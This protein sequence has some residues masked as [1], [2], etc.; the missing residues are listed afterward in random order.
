MKLLFMDTETT[1]VD[2]SIHGLTQIAGIVDEV[3][4]KN[5]I[6]VPNEIGRFNF[7]CKPFDK[8]QVS[9]KALEVQGTTLDELKTRLEPK[10]V[11]TDL[12]SLFDSQVDQYDREDKFMLIGQNPKFDYDF[13]NQWFKDNGNIYF[14]AYVDYHLIDISV[15]TTTWKLLKRMDI[16]NTKLE[17]VAKY[18]DIALKAH[19]AMNDIV[20]TREIFYI[21]ASIL[22][23]IERLITKEAS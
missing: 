9:L 14:Y 7:K 11:Y 10:S 6:L 23:R 18:F 16:V 2:P 5:G 15:F 3:D 21:Y 1:G 4:V 19:D 17:T 8:K 20:A 12:I 13:V 22:G